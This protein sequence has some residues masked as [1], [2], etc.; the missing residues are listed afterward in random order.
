MIGREWALLHPHGPHDSG[1][2]VRHGHGGDIPPTPQLG[3][4]RPLLQRRGPSRRLRVPDERAGA[5]GQ[6]H[7]HID[8]ALF[9]DG[10]ESPPQGAGVFA[11]RQAEK[12]RKVPP[13]GKAADVRHEGDEQRR[14]LSGRTEEQKR[15]VVPA[16][17]LAKY[18]GRYMVEGRAVGIP[19]R[20]LDVR[21]VQG[22]LMLDIDGRGSVLMLPLSKTLFTVRLFELEFKANERGDINEAVIPGAGVRLVRQ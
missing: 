20:T 6:E 13:R 22:E 17:T 2:V 1:E 10:P 8:V 3:L 18:A 5:V 16:E 11:R 19:F 7:A 4:H 12:A 14:A 15:T 9:A 21:L